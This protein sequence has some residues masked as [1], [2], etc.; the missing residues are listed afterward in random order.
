MLASRK[1]PPSR[2]G[3]RQWVLKPQDFAV[4][5][6]L[7]GLGEARFTYAELAAAMHLSKFEAHSAVRRLIAARLAIGEDGAVRIAAPAL[8]AFAVSGAPYAY[9]PLRGGVTIG[10]PTAYAVPPL[11]LQVVSADQSPPVWPH[12][13]GPV[14]GLALAPLYASLP[15]AAAADADLYA[16]LALFDALRIGRARERELATQMLRERIG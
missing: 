4:A 16:L 1:K 2:A 14:R 7:V 11:S 12:P 8:A 15:L 6:K 10:F 5:L 13:Q 3:Q 9:P